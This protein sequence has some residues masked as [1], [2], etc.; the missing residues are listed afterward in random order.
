MNIPNYKNKIKSTKEKFKQKI[1]CPTN[2]F[3]CLYAAH[4]KREKECI[5]SYVLKPM[6]YYENLYA[7]N[8][9]QY[10]YNLLI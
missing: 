3:R 8:L 7:N 4:Q 5:D 6:I 9:E 10:K 1:V 2:V